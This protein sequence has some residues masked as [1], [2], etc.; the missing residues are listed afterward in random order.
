MI[1]DEDE[2]LKKFINEK[3]EP[4]F[5]AAVPFTVR[6]PRLKKIGSRIKDAAVEKVMYD[7]EKTDIYFK[8][9]TGIIIFGAIVQEGKF[10][11]IMVQD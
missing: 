3:F 8:T 4:R 7:G 11:G 9:A 10:D 6:L 2:S 5:I 1:K